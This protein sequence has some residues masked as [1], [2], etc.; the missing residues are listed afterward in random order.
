MSSPPTRSPIVTRSKTIKRKEE[1]RKEREA[2][3]LSDHIDFF[4]NNHPTQTK[5]SEGSWFDLFTVRGRGSSSGGKRRKTYRR[6]SSSKKSLKTRY[7]SRR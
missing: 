3:Q 1:E 6:K 7:N 2:K 4:E 5:T